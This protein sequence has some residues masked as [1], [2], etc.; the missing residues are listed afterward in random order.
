MKSPSGTDVATRNLVADKIAALL[1]QVCQFLGAVRLNNHDSQSVYALA[2]CSRIVELA[3]PAI[4]LFREGR[5]SS[6]PILTRTIY[7]GNIDL[8]NLT[9]DRSYLKT[10]A[11]NHLAQ[12]RKV[13]DYAASNPHSPYH[14]MLAGA[15]QFKSRHSQTRSEIDAFKAEDVREVSIYAKFDMAEL[16]PEY[17]SV[18]SLLSGEA[19]N[20]IR[21]LEN[22]HMFEDEKGI[23]VELFKPPVLA[24]T[25][26]ELALLADVLHKLPEKLGRVTG[27][28]TRGLDTENI[29]QNYKEVTELM[30]LHFV[31]L[32]TS[33]SETFPNKC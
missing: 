28:N 18:Y 30:A 16:N 29:E 19:H 33:Q 23:H 13:M 8:G 6:V 7:E 14:Q 21:V 32:P 31:E 9:R 5:D 10:M 12:R 11:A 1:K 25:I 2:L 15:E 26:P 22:R 20:D 4:M 3:E 24:D 17:R 27:I